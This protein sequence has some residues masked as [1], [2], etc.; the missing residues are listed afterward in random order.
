LTTGCVPITCPILP[1]IA[2]AF[3]EEAAILLTQSGEIQ[4]LSLN[5]IN[6]TQKFVFVALKISASQLLETHL[7]GLALV[8]C[9]RTITPTNEEDFWIIQSNAYSLRPLKPSMLLIALYMQLI[10]FI[11]SLY[12]RVAVLP[13]PSSSASSHFAPLSKPPSESPPECGLLVTF[14]CCISHPEGSTN[15]KGERKSSDPRLRECIDENKSSEHTYY[16]LEL[17]KSSSLHNR[18]YI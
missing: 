11:C 8:H 4:G 1:Q 10:S 5:T 2:A 14:F 6:L 16:I 17:M 7:A 13:S 9:V 18:R 15:R 12:M 3:D